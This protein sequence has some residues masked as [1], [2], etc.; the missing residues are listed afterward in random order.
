[1]SITLHHVCGSSATRRTAASPPSCGT[2]FG[3]DRT[4]RPMDAAAA[5][6]RAVRSGTRWVSCGLPASTK[7]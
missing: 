1:M 2:A 6:A 3:S 4:P 7:P 5:R